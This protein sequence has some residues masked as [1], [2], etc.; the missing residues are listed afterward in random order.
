MNR[1]TNKAAVVLGAAGKNNMA[2]VIARRFRA[3]GAQ[4]VVA[5]RHAETLVEAQREIETEGGACLAH[6]TDIRQVEQV[7]ALVAAALARFARIDF[8]VNNAGGQFPARPSEISDR[9]WR[10]E[11][12][13]RSIPRL[14]KACCF[15]R[16]ASWN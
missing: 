2:Q 8:V 6:P 7:E 16:K 15:S 13:C 1:L 12:G 10:A 5:G 11:F 3:E 9:G 4:V 14:A